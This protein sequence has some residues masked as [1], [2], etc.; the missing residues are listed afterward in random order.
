MNKVNI[1]KGLTLVFAINDSHTKSKSTNCVARSKIAP[2]VGKIQ[3]VW[4]DIF[5]ILIVGKKMTE[6]II[7]MMEIKMIVRAQTIS[8]YY[9]H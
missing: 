8:D 5:L 7:P 2:N 6:A 3:N 1:F 4:K 9:R